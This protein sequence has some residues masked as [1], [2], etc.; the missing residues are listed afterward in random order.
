M[1]KRRAFSL[2]LLISVFLA[3][4][5]ATVAFGQTGSIYVTSKPSGAEI[6]LDG[7]PIQKKTDALIEQ[8]PVGTHQITLEHREHGKVTREVTIKEG[9]TATLHIDFQ[10]KEAKKEVEVKKE[11]EVKK[12]V[13][14]TRKETKEAR[15]EPR[16]AKKETKDAEL[17]KETKE[18]RKEIEGLPGK[19][20]EEA[21]K[22]PEKALED[23]GAYTSRGFDHFTKNQYDRAVSDFTKAIELDPN[24]LVAYYNRGVAY[25]DLGQY[26]FSIADF[27]RA[28]E[29]GL[30]GKGPYYIRG[31][32]HS[33]K[34][35][36]ALAIEDFNRVIELDPDSAN[37][38][39][40]RGMMYLLK[41][42]YEQ[43]VI[44]LTKAMELDSKNA[45]QYYFHLGFVSEKVGDKELA[46]YNFLKAR[47]TDRDILMKTSEL[48]QKQ[49]SPEMKRFYAEELVLASRHLDLQAPVLAWAKT[50]ACNSR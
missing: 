2:N 38:Y 4:F 6:S 46:R 17:R 9:L 32:A 15:K 40:S 49:K 16:D 25:F 7:N 31:L 22:E 23:A 12:E 35:D 14:E 43:T 10:P 3:I 50:G 26:D 8:M 11:A 24:L 39:N 48:L 29:L 1:M 30:K 44:D 19:G 45:A 18:V 28:M 27:T 42:Q 47:E 20:T 5:Q 41:G 37:I 34:G 36:Y 13:K 33:K 21:R